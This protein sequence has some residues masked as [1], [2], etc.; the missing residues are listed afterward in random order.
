MSEAAKLFDQNGGSANG[1]DKQTAVNSAA[2]VGSK[3]FR[4]FFCFF[5]R[6]VTDEE[7]CTDGHE[8]DVEIADE[9]NGWRWRRRRRGIGIDAL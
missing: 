3:L 8:I 7:C 5:F 6:L 2:A 1:G 4:L 9:R